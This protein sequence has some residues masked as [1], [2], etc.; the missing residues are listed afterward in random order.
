[1]MRMEFNIQFFLDYERTI[2]WNYNF[3]LCV[4]ELHFVGSCK[5]LYERNAQ[6]Y[7]VKPI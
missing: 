1:M 5:L 2:I 6:T 3:I 7:G 4:D